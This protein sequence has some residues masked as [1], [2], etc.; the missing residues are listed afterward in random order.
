[1]TGAGFVTGRVLRSR[2]AHNDEP[3]RGDSTHRRALDPVALDALS[4]RIWPGDSPIAQP[5][6][7]REQLVRPRS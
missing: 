6:A 7:R 3:S 1:M 2:P 4:G 5:S